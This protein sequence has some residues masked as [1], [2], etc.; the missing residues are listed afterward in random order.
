MI[1]RLS[2][3][4]FT[5]LGRICAEVFFMGF[6]K[7][8]LLFGI[9]GTGY[10]G[11]ELLWRGRSHG[12]MFLLG[13]L[14]FLLLGTLR[15][16]VKISLIFRLMIGAAC[17]TVLELLTG[18]AVNRNYQVWDYRGLPLH[19]RGQICLIYSLLWIP[20]CFLGMMLHGL[21]EKCLCRHGGKAVKGA[22]DGGFSAR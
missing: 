1:F 14:C 18:L 8:I 10:V 12:S 6:V 17:V 7:Q 9:G 22:S 15:R 16:L 13:G 2:S 4:N 11:L 5:F 3:K 19:Y 21:A 20:V